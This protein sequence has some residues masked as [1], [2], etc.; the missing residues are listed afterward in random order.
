MK[1]ARKMGFKDSFQNQYLG[2]IPRRSDITWQKKKK[3]PDH[4]SVVD[5]RAHRYDDS[6]RSNDNINDHWMGKYEQSTGRIDG[7]GLS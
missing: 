6:A 7:Y 1:N 2:W 3:W 4:N 5:D